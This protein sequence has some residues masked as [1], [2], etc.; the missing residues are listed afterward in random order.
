MKGSGE[1]HRKIILYCL[2]KLK[3]LVYIYYVLTHLNFYVYLFD[4]LIF[5][6]KNF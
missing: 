6:N 5:L 1:L 3:N 4:I 2:I